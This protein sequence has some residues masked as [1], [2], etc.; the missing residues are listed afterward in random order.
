MQH[1]WQT[2]ATSFFKNS[3]FSSEVKESVP[4]F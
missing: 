1:E 3:Q 4:Q 2:L